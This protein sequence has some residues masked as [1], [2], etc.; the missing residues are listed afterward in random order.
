M[1]E[2]A[3]PLHVTTDTIDATPA[4]ASGPVLLHFRARVSKAMLADRLR[5]LR[6]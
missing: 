4:T 5:T 1:S 6:D 3:G 2:G